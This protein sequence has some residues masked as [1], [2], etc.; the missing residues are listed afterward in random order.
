MLSARHD[1]PSTAYRRGQGHTVRH[2]TS[3]AHDVGHAHATAQH[4]PSTALHRRSTSLNFTISDLLRRGPIVHNG[5]LLDSGIDKR[6]RATGTGG[7]R[8]GDGDDLGLFEPVNLTATIDGKDDGAV[9][10]VPEPVS[11]GSEPV[12]AKC[13]AG[14][15]A[16]GS[17]AN[18]TSHTGETVGSGTDDGIRTGDPPLRTVA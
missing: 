1:R 4:P 6:C 12:S 18:E 14:S 16:R 2:P 17:L 9:A 15:E 3:S 7:L 13:R 5:V 11:P 10:Q 8:R